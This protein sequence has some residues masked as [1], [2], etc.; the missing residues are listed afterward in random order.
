MN[1]GTPPNKIERAP[2]AC[3]PVV[4]LLR[5]GR[6]CERVTRRFHRCNENVGAGAVIDRDGRTG[7]VD[8][9]L[10]ARSMHLAHRAFQGAL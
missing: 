7:M 6:T 4:E 5:R 1:C 9:Q 3:D 10:L 8:E 2:F